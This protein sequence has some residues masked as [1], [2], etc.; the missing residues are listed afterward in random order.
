MEWSLDMD[1]ATWRSQL[2]VTKAFQLGGQDK[3]LTE[4]MQQGPG[5]H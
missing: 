5:G 3:G 1:M 4:W 2:S